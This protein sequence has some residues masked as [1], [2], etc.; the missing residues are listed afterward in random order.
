MLKHTHQTVALTLAL[1]VA[2]AC[3]PEEAAPSPDG[4]I[5]LTIRSMEDVDE[6]PLAEAMGWNTFDI[7]PISPDEVFVYGGYVDVEGVAR[8]HVGPLTPRAIDDKTV[9]ATV[10]LGVPDAAFAVDGSATAFI[11]V[12]DRALPAAG[13]LAS[14]DS[15]VRFDVR[16]PTYLFESDTP[17]LDSHGY[18]DAWL[19]SPTEYIGPGRYVLVGAAAS[20]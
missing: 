3:G 8:L 15:D 4:V 12:I 16:Q 20:R 9:S 18:T 1:T 10:E 7:L 19:S 14:L 11:V 2:A 13:D 6:D 5:E 17:G